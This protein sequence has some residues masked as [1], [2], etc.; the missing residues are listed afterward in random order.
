MTTAKKEK[1]NKPDLS[2][3]PYCVEAELARAMMNGETKYG[4][5]NYCLGHDNTDLC[6]AAKRHIGRY[7]AG[8]T[9][10]PE[11]KVHHLAHAM[12][13]MLMI[14]HQEDLGTS[15]DNRHKVVATD[16]ELFEVLNES[17]SQMAAYLAEPEPEH[18]F[19]I[20]ARS[21]LSGEE[22]TLEACPDIILAQNRLNYY[23]DQWP[24]YTLSIEEVANGHSEDS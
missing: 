10:D 21:N 7:L 1:S 14:I 17:V 4:R 22:F 6:G 11:S 9:I 8:E 16:A 20:H 18:F 12:A 2:L 3:I 23:K 15:R 13:N 19:E 5:Y 24:T